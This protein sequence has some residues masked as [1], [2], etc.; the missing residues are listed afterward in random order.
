MDSLSKIASG[1][2]PAPQPH[3]STRKGMDGLLEGNAERMGV[4]SFA[5]IET[6]KGMVATSCGEGVGFNRKAIEPLAG[7]FI[8]Q[9]FV[10]W[11]R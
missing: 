3:P 10:C 5:V 11:V 7:G 1:L 4:I 8:E 9:F 6:W 2:P